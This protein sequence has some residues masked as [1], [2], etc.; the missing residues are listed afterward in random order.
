MESLLTPKQLTEIL[1]LKRSCVYRMLRSG[2]LPCVCVTTGE[3]KLS[4]RVRPSMLEKW[5]KARE[6]INKPQKLTGNEG[7]QIP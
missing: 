7:A 3:R 5:L 2:E 6:I 1:G 4:L